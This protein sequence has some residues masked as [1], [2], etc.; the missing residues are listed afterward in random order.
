MKAA[1]CPAYSITR[2]IH[3]FVT[4]SAHCH[5]SQAAGS[6]AHIPPK[7][8]PG[9]NRPRG[10][11]LLGDQGS[12]WLPQGALPRP[13]QEQPTGAGAVRSVQSVSAVQTAVGC[14][15]NA[16]VPVLEHG[17]PDPRSYS[18]HGPG[19]PQPDKSECLFQDSS[20]CVCRTF[21]KVSESLE[22]DSP[23]GNPQWHLCRLIVTEAGVADK[24][25][26][27]ESLQNRLVFWRLGN[28]MQRRI[29]GLQTRGQFLQ[30][31]NVR[32]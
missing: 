4:T 24:T 12:L 29:E 2:L 9:G 18:Q 31:I 1:S 22:P 19:P 16:P 6:Q 13:V 5:D 3:S 21:L 27:G 8:N 10:T 11:P 20:Q 30:A 26:L 17:S 14:P 7:R 23:L 15:W 25:T 28:H 32:L